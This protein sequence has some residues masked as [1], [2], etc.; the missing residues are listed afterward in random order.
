[1]TGLEYGLSLG[2]TA[3]LSA[4]TGMWVYAKAVN[5]KIPKLQKQMT[6]ME[7]KFTAEL[8]ILK[9]NFDTACV[10]INAQLKYAGERL[11]LLNTNL[12]NGWN[13]KKHL[14]LEKQVARL[15]TT[16]PGWDGEERR[17]TERPRK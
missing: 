12:N 5:S 16:A 15:E 3:V 11:D 4:L 9:S 13:C 1:M 14:E 2:G 17:K 7:K 6:D 10:G 8:N